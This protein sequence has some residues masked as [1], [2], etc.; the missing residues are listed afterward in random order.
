MWPKSFI[1]WSL[2]EV[3]GSSLR[4]KERKLA[5]LGAWLVKKKVLHPLEDMLGRNLKEGRRRC[6]GGSRL[7]R[8]LPTQRPG[9]EEEYGRRPRGFFL[10]KKRY[11]S[12]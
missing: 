4:K 12:I 3:A 9:L 1:S 8:S 5:S 6:L 11:T 10:Q 2:E 7:G